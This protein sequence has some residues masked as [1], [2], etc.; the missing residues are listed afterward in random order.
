MQSSTTGMRSKQTYLPRLAL[1]A[2]LAAACGSPLETITPPPPPPGLTGAAPFVVSNPVALG[3]NGGTA[4]QGSSGTDPV[5][6]ISLVPGT[7]PEV[8]AVRIRVHRNGVVVTAALV[9]GGLDP[10]AVPAIAGDTITLTATRVSGPDSVL[11]FVVPPRKPPIIVRTEPKKNKRDVAVNLRIQVVFSEPIDAASLTPENFDLRSGSTT[12]A[13]QLRFGN[14]ERTI[15]E[16]IPAEALA[17]ATNYELVLGTG[18]RDLEGTAIETGE[19]ISFTTVAA[20]VPPG[21]IAVTTVTTGTGGPASGYWISVDYGSTRAIGVNG[22]ITVGDLAPGP[23][24]VA[25]TGAGV[26]CLAGANPRTVFVPAGGSVNIEFAVTCGVVPVTQL[27]FVRDG[28]IQLANSDGTGIVQLTHTGPGVSNHHPTW[29]PDGQR[30]AFASNRAGGGKW[31]IYIMNADG[32]NVVQLTDR[33][34]ATEPAWSP[35]GRS[36]AV[37]ALQDGSAGVFAVD[38][39]GGPGIRVVVNRPGYDGSPAWSPDG[40]KISFTSDW[41]AYDFVYDLYV[42]NADG[43]DIRSV[44]EGPFFD[45]ST[46]YWQS[47]W[48]PDGTKLAVVVCARWSYYPCSPV[49]AV[50]VVNPDGSGLTMLAQAGIFA[51]PTW[52]PDGR[53]IVFA[54]T[55]VGCGPSQTSLRFVRADGSA[56]GLILTNGHSPAWRP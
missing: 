11:V 21:E 7:L 34:Y 16:F 18:I 46:D 44:V 14:Q 31:E 19:T 1:L 37:V 24:A 41:R 10:V 53:T 3:S 54:S 20:P 56:E 13:G 47:A 50:A 8:S 32:S 55:C 29:S 30:L 2:A 39:D 5:A 27:A 51:R 42:V 33:G 6:F 36:I 17:V 22:T 35:D 43:T 23:H 28:Q 4:V 48:S 52:S 15:V 38:A 9:D 26:H 25:L 49:S 12:V 45:P 40:R